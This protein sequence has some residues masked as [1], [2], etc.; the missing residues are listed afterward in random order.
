MYTYQHIR[1]R[2]ARSR[3]ICIVRFH[4]SQNRRMFSWEMWSETNRSAG[5]TWHTPRSV[6]G[7]YRTVI[8]LVCCSYT[9]AKCYPVFYPN[10]GATHRNPKSLPTT[11]LHTGNYL[12]HFN[13]LKFFYLK[14]SMRYVGVKWNDGVGIQH[15]DWA[16]LG[17]ITDWAALRRTEKISHTRTLLWAPKGGNYWRNCMTDVS[18]ASIN[19]TYWK[20]WQA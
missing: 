10:D 1:W 13:D 4:W 15:N 11:M 18:S 16:R 14:L 7:F 6:F 19:A 17:F 20:R 12:K 3:L 2:W 5:C 9:L 8:F